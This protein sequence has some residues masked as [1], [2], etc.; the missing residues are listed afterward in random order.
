MIKRVEAAEFI[1]LA[2]EVPVVDVRSPGEFMQGHIPGAFNLPL[3]D[4]SER[5]VVGTIYK[6]SGPGDA[7]LKGLELAGPKLASFVKTLSAAV[8]GKDLLVHCWRGGM[9]SEQM[10][11]LFGQAGF[12]PSLLS[13]GYKAYRKY[14]REDFS[15]HSRLIILGGMTGSGKTDILRA[16]ERAGEQVLD[17]EM[18][19]NHK[20]SVF[21]ALG[22]SPQPTNEQFE[23]DLAAIWQQFDFARP[24][25]LE[26]ESRMI[27]NVSLPDPLFERMIRSLMVVVEMPMELRINRLVTEYS[28]FGKPDLQ[29]SILKIA[30]KLG[31][32]RC[33]EAMKLLDS[34]DFHSLAGLL[35]GYYDKAYN[36]AVSRRLCQDIVYLKSEADDPEYN[37][38]KVRELILSIQM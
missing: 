16:L 17:L 4:D 25:W 36:H 13:G 8:P 2:K 9:R 19:A 33:N 6:N 23:N 26:D 31:G 3:F 7:V 28:Q 1:L 24:I 35:L 12:R 11:W 29:E 20:G 27:G 37:A 21:G 32:T 14:I 30:E 18:T 5:A 38:R 10:A 15:R 22:Q 34:G